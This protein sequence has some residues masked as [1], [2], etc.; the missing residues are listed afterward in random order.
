MHQYR[1]SF[2]GRWFPPLAGNRMLWGL[3]GNTIH[4][5]NVRTTVAFSYRHLT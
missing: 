1:Y 5:D 3:R 2:Q 4:I